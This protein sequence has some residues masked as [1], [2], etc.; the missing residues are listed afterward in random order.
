MLRRRA[1]TAAVVACLAGAAILAVGCGGDEPGGKS[2]GESTK[3]YLAGQGEVWVV[4]VPSGTTRRVHAPVGGGD[5]P[6]FIA[7]AGDRFV[8]WDGRAASLPLADPDAH[9]RKIARG[10]WIFIPALRRDAI[11]IAY[12]ARGPSRSGAIVRLR[13]IDGE[14]RTLERTGPTPREGAWPFADVG[15]GLVFTDGAGG[16]LW[17]PRRQRIV[18]RFPGGRYGEIGAGGPDEL[19]SCLDRCRTLGLIDTDD[20]SRR[21]VGAPPGTRLVA[22]EATFSPDGT[23]LAVPLLR[24]GDYRAF[25]KH[26]RRLAIVDVATGEIRVVPGSSV[27]PGYTFTAWSADGERAFLTGGERHREIVT[28]KSDGGRAEGIDAAVGSFYD[29]FAS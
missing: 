29:L 22:N 11:W 28:V 10:G 15:G 4:D 20:G 1:L 14:G 12:L 2:G 3:L 24:S 27:D 13:E 23:Q 7:P 16:V 6:H 5:Y 21:L 18:R 8:V 9:P 17:D 26:G 25:Y 19:A